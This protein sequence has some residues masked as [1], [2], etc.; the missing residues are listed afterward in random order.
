MGFT[1]L[2]FVILAIVW[3]AVL[4]PLLLSRREN[5]LLDEVEP[6]EPFTPSVT[7]V[8]R[9][10]PL[11]TAE[12]GTAIVSTPLLRRAALAE[13]DLLEHR[14][15]T[16]RRT[17]LAVLTAI[18]T[19]VSVLAALQK[20]AWWSPLVPLALIGAFVAVA[21]VTVVRM[22]EDLAARALDVRTS[23]DWPEATVSIDVLGTDD[24][25][26][27]QCVDL[28]APIVVTASL[29][30]PVPITR[31][32]YVSKPLGPRTVR[33][34]D[35]SAPLVAPAGGIPVTADA[36][37]APEPGAEDEGRAVNE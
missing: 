12:D 14:A 33:T 17:V 29:R 24:S 18:A 15:A 36:P 2:I 19:G 4:L 27:E 7:I 32:T 8:R 5:D 3:L 11:D 37:E 25:D 1:G 16:R 26:H 30:D 20:V 22:R 10:V 35:L 31:S 9:G 28:T 6:G 13:L 34:I 23:H 21:R